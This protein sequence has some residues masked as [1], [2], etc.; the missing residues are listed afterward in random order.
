MNLNLRFPSLALAAL[1]A[2]F[3]LPA[4]AHDYRVGPLH[5]DH[6]WARPT[7]P[8][9]Q[10]GG[11]F[12]KIA[13][14]GE[15]DDKLLSAHSPVA[16][17]TEV[18]SMTMDGHVMRMREIPELPVPAGQAVELRPGGYHVM[19][20]GLRAPLKAGESVPLTLRFER[21]GEVTVAVKVEMRA[22]PAQPAGGHGTG[23]HHHH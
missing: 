23:G 1:L 5:I 17:S 18:H 20:M 7:V 9:Q 11:A 12:M 13:N 8:G 6:P 3:T 14:R 16:A 22:Q 19:F 2:A 21:A 10:S 4:A 15:V